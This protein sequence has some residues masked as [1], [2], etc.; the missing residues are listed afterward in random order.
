MKFFIDGDAFPN[1]LKPI[2]FK[3]IE[4]Y[5]LETY[6]VSNKKIHIG[7]SKQIQYLIVDQGLD[8]ADDLIVAMVGTNDL[9]ITADIPL[10]DRV[11][12]KGSLALD[13]RGTLFDEDNIKGHLS[14]RNLMQEIRESGELTR[15]PA[16]FSKK[17]T[18]NFA[19]QL[20]NVLYKRFR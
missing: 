18:H 6:V 19:T 12:S 8:E 5:K 17:D 4:K 7:D 16:P 11:V 2:V 20:N 13:H 1:L 10:A 9:V 3:A 14:M 15:G